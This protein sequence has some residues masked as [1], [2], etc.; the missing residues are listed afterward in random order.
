[1][2]AVEESWFA[3]A[4]VVEP[5]PARRPRRRAP[6][7]PHRTPKAAGNVRW[8]SAASPATLPARPRASTRPRR[9][10]VH[11]V[12]AHIVWMV[13]FAVLLAGVVA[14]NVAVLRANVSVHQLDQEIAQKQAQI[15][16]QQS[17]L[18]AARSAPRVEAAAHQLGLVQAPAASTGYLDLLAP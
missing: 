1:M 10:H 2:A 4:A 3:P 15:Q 17:Q 5:L 14:V 16:A 7:R 11:R 8:A 6:E 9:R 18:S 13:L 12:R